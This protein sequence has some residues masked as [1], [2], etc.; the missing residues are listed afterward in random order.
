MFV[1][2]KIKVP[3]LHP[4]KMMLAARPC[5]R[6]EAGLDARNPEGSHRIL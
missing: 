4:I 3:R 6:R 5:D 1:I 2:G